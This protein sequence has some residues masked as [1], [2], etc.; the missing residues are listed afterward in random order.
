M[1]R[2]GL[3]LMLSAIASVSLAAPVLAIAPGNDLYAGRTVI[4]AIPFTETLDTTEATT[5][6]LDAEF[7]D[8]CAAP[9]TDASVWYEYTA[10]SDVGLIAETFD[11]DYSVGLIVATGAPGSFSVVTCGPFS[12]SFFAATG[13]TYTILYFDFQ[14]DGGGNGGSLTVGLRE[15]PPPPELEISIAKTG[16]FN[17]A[18][19]SATIRGTVTCTGGDE[20]SKT[21]IDFQV[22]Q[23]VGRFRINGQGFAT[24]DCDGAAHEWAGEV[25]ASDG[26]FAGG[27]ASVRLFALACTDSGC[28]EV[29]LTATVTLRR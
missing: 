12:V 20:F 24:F 23:S 27:K 25:F 1:K 13:E 6:A 28:D 16:S 7:L 29:E 17:A 9:A 2:A 14:E 21:F 5:D 8:Q 19:G 15:M 22:T 18:T 3:V 26:T 11:A 10:S 4:P